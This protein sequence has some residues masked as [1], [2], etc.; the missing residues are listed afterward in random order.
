MIRSDQITQIYVTANKHISIFAHWSPAENPFWAGLLAH[1]T[2]A[3]ERAQEPKKL[4]DLLSPSH[5][6]LIKHE[7]L[8]SDHLKGFFLMEKYLM[9]SE[10]NHIYQ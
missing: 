4:S 10:M 3:A 7:G 6:R 9:K 2:A 1:F 5:R 8:R